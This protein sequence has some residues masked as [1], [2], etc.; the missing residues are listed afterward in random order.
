MGLKYGL[1]I[2]WILRIFNFLIV[3]PPWD[4]PHLFQRS[5]SCPVEISQCESIR[6]QPAISRSV[7]CDLDGVINEKLLPEPRTERRPANAHSHL[8][9]TR[10]PAGQTRRG[11]GEGYG[12]SFAGLTKAL[13]LRWLDVYWWTSRQLVRHG[14]PA[15]DL[16][17]RLP[18]HSFY[19]CRVV[20]YQIRPLCSVLVR[21]GV[22][23]R[24]PTTGIDIPLNCGPG[25]VF[26][27]ETDN[28]VWVR[29]NSSWVSA[30]PSVCCT[31]LSWHQL[32][33]PAPKMSRISQITR[34]FQLMFSACY[35]A[36]RGK[37]KRIFLSAHT[38]HAH[39]LLFYKETDAI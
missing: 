15:S 19:T 25:Q 31:D 12:C 10:Y 17:Y 35:N 26:N 21:F 11:S 32:N 7:S 33:Q 2:V 1:K 28:L 4:P 9:M 36:A 23:T 37:S 34:T 6:G 39:S 24:G 16:T 5:G 3:H 18:N 20:V 38:F 14:Q 8:C 27:I 22:G 13:A 30:S 29:G